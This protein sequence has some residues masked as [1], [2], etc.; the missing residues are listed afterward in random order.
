LLFQF[1]YYPFNVPICG[2]SL[3]LSMGLPRYNI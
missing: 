3:Q 1:D 2:S